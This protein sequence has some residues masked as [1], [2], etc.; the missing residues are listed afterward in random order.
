[1]GEKNIIS[2]QNFATSALCWKKE[3]EEASSSNVNIMAKCFLNLEQ[4]ES[5]EDE[6]INFEISLHFE[7]ANGEVILLST[8]G[9]K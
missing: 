2:W 3:P 1:M 7:A 8:K 6:D 5:D 4:R 9:T